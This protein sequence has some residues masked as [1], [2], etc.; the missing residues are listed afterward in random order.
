M[1]TPMD[2]ERRIQPSVVSFQLASG[3]ELRGLSWQPPEDFDGVLLPPCLLV[4]G[5]ASNA[6]LWDGVAWRLAQAGHPVVAI[7]QRG[8]GHS[9]KPDSGYEMATVADDLALLIDA[10]Q[11]KQPLVAGQS[12]G[13]NVVIELAYRHPSSARAIAC[14]D[15]GFIELKQRFPNWEDAQEVMAPPKMIGM[16]FVRFQA[17]MA[18]AYPDWPEEGRQG[19]LANFEVRADGTIAPWLTFER[20]MQVLHGLWEHSPSTRYASINT[21]VLWLPADTGE[22]DWTHSK[23]DAILSAAAALAH[24]RI[25]WFSPA[26]HDVH[27]QHPSDVALLLHRAATEPDWISA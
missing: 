7:D 19:Q 17:L 25:E 11:W 13:A 21:P 22:V 1:T 4:H 2:T 15:G 18:G 27:A 14:V 12:W 23:E 6:R 26:H 9:S 8:H 3:V 5:L 20:H 24:T 10:M 16:P